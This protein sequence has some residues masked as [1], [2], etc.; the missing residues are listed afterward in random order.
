[1]DSSP[2]EKLSKLFVGGLSHDTTKESLKAYFEQYGPVK[3]CNVVYNPTTKKPRGFGYIT[4]QDHNSAQQVLNIKNENG[5]HVIDSKQCEVKRAIP[6]DAKSEFSHEKTDK[7]FIGGLH[8]DAT[9]K[10]VEQ[11]LIE[12][13]GHPPKSIS[14]MLRKEDSSKNRG[15]CFVELQLTDDADTL[16]CI[17]NI[18]ILGKMAEIKKSNPQGRG[19]VKAADAFKGAAASPAMAGGYHY[20]SPYGAAAYGGYPPYDPYAGYFYESPMYS[21]YGYMPS[22]G[23]NGYS[24]MGMYNNQSASSFGP[25]KGGTGAGR[26]FRPY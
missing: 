14:L 20:P 3:D 24:G 9:Q 11:V 23:A 7:I 12:Q 15:Y 26:G 2:E 19:G 1:M 5:P 13:L 10:D 18:D 22:Y 6:R 17:K 21:G 25:S 8:E 16:Y 4:F